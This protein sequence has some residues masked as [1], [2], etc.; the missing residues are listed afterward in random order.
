MG[1]RGSWSP[2]TCYTPPSPSPLSK[3]FESLGRRKEELKVA[4]RDDGEKWAEREGGRADK[5]RR[6]RA[7]KGEFQQFMQTC[8]HKSFTAFENVFPLKK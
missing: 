5:G 4:H 2:V 3:S 8:A 1:A 6:L 7:E